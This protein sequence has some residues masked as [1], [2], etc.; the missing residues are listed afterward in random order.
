METTSAGNPV[1][2]YNEAVPTLQ[3]EPAQHAPVQA[4]VPAN[5]ELQ[6]EVD[7]DTLLMEDSDNLS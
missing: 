5:P 7:D 2:F 6:L 1:L 3:P 4:E